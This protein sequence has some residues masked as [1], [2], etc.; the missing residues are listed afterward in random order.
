MAY[1]G[2][3]MYQFQAYNHG[4]QVNGQTILNIIEKIDAFSSLVTRFLKK[5]GLPDFSKIDPNEYYSQQKWLNAFRLISDRVGSSV[6]FQIGKKMSENVVFPLEIDNIESALQSIDIV[7][8]MNHR[9]SEGEVLFDLSRNSGQVLL[10]GIGFYSFHKVNSSD[11]IVMVCENPHP[12]DYDLGV[13]TG[14]AQR[15]EPN[16]IVAHDGSKPCRKHDGKS[17]TYIILIGRRKT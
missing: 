14:M 12:C 17:C 4:I 5:V 15:F 10:E 3:S 6:T 13:I 2:D 7:Y 11:K 16:S 8:H 1:Q 9:N